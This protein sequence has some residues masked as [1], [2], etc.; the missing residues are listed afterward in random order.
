MNLGGGDVRCVI[1]LT[2]KRINVM[3]HIREFFSLIF[4]NFVEFLMMNDD[5]IRL[6][7]VVQRRPILR[8]CQFNS[9]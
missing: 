9:N 7:K 6:F 1:S 5:M 4:F 8:V 3:I 2:R